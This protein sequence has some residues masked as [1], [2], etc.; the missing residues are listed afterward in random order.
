MVGKVLPSLAATQ[1]PPIKHSVYL[2][3][4]TVLVSMA[5]AMIHLQE[6]EGK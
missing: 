4:A 1:R 3:P 2:I 5:V 6:E